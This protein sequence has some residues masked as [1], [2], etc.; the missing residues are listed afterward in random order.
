[1][2]ELAQVYARS[3]FQV[4]REQ[5]KLDVLREQLGQVADAIGSNRELQT[6]F[7]SPYFSTEEK[8]NALD[9]VLV[10]AEA[11]LVNFLKLLIEKHRMPVIARI[12]AQYERLW[13]EENR[14]LPVEVTSA[15]ALDPA[16]TEEIGNAIGERTGRRVELAARVDPNIIGGIVVRIGN[17]ILDA[18]IRN[19]LEQLRRTV[20][21]G[22]S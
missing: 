13:E 11:I 20:A 7:F 5:G 19:R 4:A 21:Q 6:F 16:T 2:E 14:L 12:R 3:L 8:E 15:I 17:S 22:A 18:S 9:V 1:M 10:G